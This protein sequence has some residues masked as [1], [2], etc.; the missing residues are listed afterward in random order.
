MFAADCS[1]RM[2]PAAHLLHRW[3]QNPLCLLILT[4]VIPTSLIFCSVLF[5]LLVR[6]GEVVFFIVLECLQTWDT[7]N[8]AEFGSN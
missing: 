6:I 7:I 2:G 4:E 1:L 3:R 5:P 8:S